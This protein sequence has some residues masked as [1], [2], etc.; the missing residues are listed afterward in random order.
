MN[1]QYSSTSLPG[2]GGKTYDTSSMYYGTLLGGGYIL[3]INKE[4][5]LDMYGKYFWTHQA[6]DTGSLATGERV[7][8]DGVTSQRLRHGVRLTAKG[9]ISPYV[10]AAL[11]HE[12]AGTARATVANNDV[13]E[14]SLRGTTGMAE[15]GIK[16]KPFRAEAL[17]FD[18]S[19][20]G[21]VGKREGVLGRLE[22]R[23][24]F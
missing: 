6:G 8:F 17:S 14:P 20:H 23:Y 10:G 7:E 15:I 5:S 2:A 21:Y 19:M 1:N 3:N 22:A 24:E 13:G 9:Y 12:L 18:L 16:S 11:E 4:I